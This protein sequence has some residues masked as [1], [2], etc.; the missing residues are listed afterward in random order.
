MIGHAASEA[1]VVVD[2]QQRIVALN[3]AAQ[4]MFLCS[5]ASVLA[6]RWPA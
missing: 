3:P 1:I 6:S 4:R 5:P 2:Q